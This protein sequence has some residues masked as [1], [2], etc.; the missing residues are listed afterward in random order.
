M[1]SEG[2]LEETGRGGRR[3]RSSAAA[4]PVAGPLRVQQ[5]RWASTTLASPFPS[6]VRVN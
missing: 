2:L 6:N 5:L 1:Q 3:S 4:P